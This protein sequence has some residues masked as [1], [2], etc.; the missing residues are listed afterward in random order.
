PNTETSLES[1]LEEGIL[2]PEE[3][4]KLYQGYIFLRRLID[5][6]RMVRGHSRDLVVPPRGSHEFLLL[7]KRMGYL[8]TPRY[9]PDAQ[10]DW[11]LSHALRAVRGIFARRFLAETGPLGQAEP[12][13]PAGGGDVSVSAAF[14]D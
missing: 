13:H 8:A 6:L 12:A 4:E 2:D 3:F 1:L 14:L 9:E 5:A 7:A 11:D 10:L